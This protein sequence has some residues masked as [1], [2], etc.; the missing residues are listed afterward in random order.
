MLRLQRN[1]RGR[2]D[3]NLQ[4]PRRDVLPVDID[5]CYYG[6][7]RRPLGPSAI[8]LCLDFI[9]LERVDCD[10]ERYQLYLH[11]T[12]TCTGSM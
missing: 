12:C 9:E 11:M 6:V 1:G 4:S 8:A 5:Q 7:W 10:V 2:L 3:S